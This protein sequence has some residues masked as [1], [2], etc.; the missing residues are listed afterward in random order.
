MLCLSLTEL[1]VLREHGLVREVVV[2]R[3]DGVALRLQPRE[4]CQSKVHQLV[5]L[6]FGIKFVKSPPKSSGLL[7]MSF[8][9]I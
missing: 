3:R 8:G 9:E 1:L 5:G 4:V 6:H 2:L 7:E